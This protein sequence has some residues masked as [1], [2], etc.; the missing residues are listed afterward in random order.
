MTE[1]YQLNREKVE[2]SENLEVAEAKLKRLQ[3]EMEDLMQTQHQT[4]PEVTALKRDKHQLQSKIKGESHRI[5]V[6]TPLISEIADA[7]EYFS[8]FVSDSN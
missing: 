2:L 6:L 5:R 8:D 3:E 4:E 1:V 7:Q